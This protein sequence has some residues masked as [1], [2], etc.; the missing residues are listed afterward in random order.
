MDRGSLQN[1]TVHANK[2]V[3]A[4]KKKKSEMTFVVTQ[5]RKNG[6]ALGQIF[7]KVFALELRQI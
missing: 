6:S 5:I 2:F 3:I 4:K 7:V 1:K